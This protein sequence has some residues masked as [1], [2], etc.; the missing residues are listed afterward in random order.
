[1]FY[2]W[3]VDKIKDGYKTNIFFINFYYRINK[4]IF[5]IILF[6]KIIEKI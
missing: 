4:Y 1:M 3:K 6:Q 2:A 5:Y